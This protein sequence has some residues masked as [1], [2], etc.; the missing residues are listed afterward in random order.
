MTTA[1][2][3]LLA[4]GRIDKIG[5]GRISNDNHAWLKQQYD[6]GVRFSDWPKGE[7][8]ESK[9]ADQKPVIRVKRDPKLSTEKVVQDFTILY[10]RDAYVAVSTDGKEYGMAEVCNNCRVSLVQNQ[11][12]RPTILGDIRVT[13]KAR[14]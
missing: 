8:V 6:S 3:A 11:C 4:A 7:V 9:D 1:K 14:K 10:D 13:I 12:E 2:E 5:R